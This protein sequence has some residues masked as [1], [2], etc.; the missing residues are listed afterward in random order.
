[1]PSP[2]E[3]SSDKAKILRQVKK[4]LGMLSELVEKL[5]NSTIALVSYFGNLAPQTGSEFEKALEKDPVCNL[6]DPSEQ[7]IKFL[8]FS[9]DYYYAMVALE[10]LLEKLQNGKDDEVIMCKEGDTKKDDAIEEEPSIEDD[11]IDD[12][13]IDSIDDDSIDAIKTEALPRILKCLVTIDHHKLLEFAEGNQLGN[14]GFAAFYVMCECLY[15]QEIIAI[16][17]FFWF[18]FFAWFHNLLN[19]SPFFSCFQF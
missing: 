7:W 16:C 12:D 5:T 13:S 15:L 10:A 3:E 9:W 11:S 6:D 8:D 18:N 19:S 1:M 2:K 17:K 4:C 14:C